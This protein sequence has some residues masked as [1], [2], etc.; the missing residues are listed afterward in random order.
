MCENSELFIDKWWAGDP[1][2]GCDPLSL[3]N[4]LSPPH[5]EDYVV[6]HRGFS[7]GVFESALEEAELRVV[8]QQFDMPSDQKN[9]SP[10][11]KMIVQSISNEYTDEESLKNALEGIVG[12]E[13]FKMKGVR[14]T[15]PTIYRSLV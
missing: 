12:K 9:G 3:T 4:S 10:S 7:S 2:G 15:I 6:P 13:K 14:P 5:L 8:A 11:V 1:G